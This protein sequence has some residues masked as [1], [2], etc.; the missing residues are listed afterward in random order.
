MTED[1]TMILDQDERTNAKP[2]MRP[3]LLYGAE[4]IGEYLGMTEREVR[5]QIEV[6]GLPVIRMGMRRMAARPERLDAWLD[7]LER[8][9]EHAAA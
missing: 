5:H 6:S 7:E 8:Q 3:A 2:W 4:A 1:S 9:Q